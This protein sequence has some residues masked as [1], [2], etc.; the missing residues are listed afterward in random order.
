MLAL[1][2]TNTHKAVGISIKV[3]PCITLSLMTDRLVY[4]SGIQ[5]SLEVP[6]NDGCIAISDGQTNF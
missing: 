1:C 5:L 6:D 4:L 3:I 2:A